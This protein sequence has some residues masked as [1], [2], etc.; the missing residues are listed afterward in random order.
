MG[1]DLIADGHKTTSSGLVQ[2]DVI[3][4]DL[5]PVQVDLALVEN[6]FERQGKTAHERR[7]IALN[8]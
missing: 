7:L 5:F 4:P 1:D 3:G 8:D 2:F 6:A